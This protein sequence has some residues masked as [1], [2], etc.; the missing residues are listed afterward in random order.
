MINFTH[1]A[2][3]GTL[4][5]GQDPGGRSQPAECLLPGP[6]GQV[7][8]ARHRHACP[9]HLRRNAHLHHDDL[10]GHSSQNYHNCW[11]S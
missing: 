7:G 11:R 9:E 4:Y 5:A 8:L 2:I 3:P 1:T 6:L 10:Q